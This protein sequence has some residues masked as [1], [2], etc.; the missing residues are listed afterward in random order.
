MSNST[1]LVEAFLMQHG[2]ALLVERNTPVK[3]A[4]DVST[5]SGWKLVGVSAYSVR[6][7]D[8]NNVW[9]KAD[10]FFEAGKEKLS[11][12]ITSTLTFLDANWELGE[13]QYEPV[14]SPEDDDRDETIRMIMA[15][16]V[17]C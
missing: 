2:Q 6:D 16:P 13:I 10:V 14:N 4:M 5:V 7:A 12:A 8:K 1:R 17:G 3:A 9:F 11:V 15:H